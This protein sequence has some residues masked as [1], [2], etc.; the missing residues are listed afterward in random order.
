[1]TFT[2]QTVDTTSAAQTATL[3]NTGSGPRV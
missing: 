3:T 2:G 1:L